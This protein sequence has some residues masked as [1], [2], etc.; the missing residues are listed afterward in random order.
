MQTV[1]HQCP[2]LDLVDHSTIQ[3]ENVAGKIV[4]VMI[5]ELDHDVLPE[6]SRIWV[7]L[8]DVRSSTWT[9]LSSGS[10]RIRADDSRILTHR[11]TRND[12]EQECRKRKK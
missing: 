5:V 7:G 10:N 2:L 6:V 8:D 9:Q 11:H 4:R 1:R 3:I 12:E